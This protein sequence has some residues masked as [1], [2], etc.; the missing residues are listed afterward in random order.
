MRYYNSI[1]DAIGRTPL[2]RLSRVTDGLP[3]TLLAKVESL[4]PGGSV[5]DRIGLAMIEKAERTGLLQPGGTII[6]A[7]AGNTGVGL[8][9]VAASKGYRCIFVMPDKMSEDK[10]NLLRAYGAEVVITPTAVPPD[11]PESY[12]GVADRLARE[13]PGAFRP[14]QFANL[15][16]P[17]AH[18]R[19][20]GPEIWEDTDGKV[21]VFVAGMGTG[22]TI[23]GIGRYLKK[24]NPKVIVVGADPE[25]SV[26]SG[27]SPRSYK[28]EGIGEDFVPYTFDR[29][30][31]DEMVRVSDAE[32]F[33][34][35][36]RLA[37]EEGLLVGGSS[38]TAV[39][40]AIAYAR[41]LEPGKVI[42]AL[43]PDTGRNYL[44]KIYSDR[45]MEENGFLEP[46]Q[47][48]AT[49][50]DVLLSKRGMPG[51]I[52]IAPEEPAVEAVLR[53]ERYGISQLPVLAGDQVL[54][55]VN[56]VTLV[57]LLHDG[58]D[59]AA[60]TASEVM[61]KPL[62]AVDAATDVSEVYRLL[63]AGHGGVIVSH[64]GAP[65]GLL[66]RIDLVNYWTGRGEERR[67]A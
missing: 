44:S 37:R 53:M 65:I 59:L 43:L 51:L 5:K 19:T 7:T 16:N 1:L 28:V 40:A 57:K 55:S 38:G 25:G 42:V 49:A 67:A 15:A 41:R 56:E 46:T 62:P 66:A 50:G 14:N 58:V 61:G 29:R 24:R 2:I 48:R 23:S 35:A 18:Y 45:W 33:R 63:L 20:T 32:S 64:E 22:G 4:N 36:R 12:N 6:E 11:S 13:I 60:K 47:E 30:V 54:G 26:L 31:V 9:L 17:E 21:D 39:A 34:M 27:D 10:V 8:A 52:A 3:V